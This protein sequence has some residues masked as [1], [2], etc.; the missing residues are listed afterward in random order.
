MQT[1]LVAFWLTVALPSIGFGFVV[2]GAT[3]G[4]NT[5]TGSR[6][7]RYD[8]EDFYDSGP[9]WDLYLLSLHSIQHLNQSDLTSYFQI[10]GDTGS[11]TAKQ[12]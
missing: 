12:I 9:A 8:I 10:S 5:T 7:L 2:T 3:G 1:N 11:S 4:L 6:P